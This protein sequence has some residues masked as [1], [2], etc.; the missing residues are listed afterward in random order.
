MEAP[1]MIIVLQK[2]NPFYVSSASANRTRS[3]IEG[4]EKL[5]VEILLY[6]TNGYQTSK[7][8]AEMGVSGFIGKIEYKYLCTNYSEGIWKKRLDAYVLNVFRSFQTI[9]S[10]NKVFKELKQSIVWVTN[11]LTHLKAIK[12]AKK[13]NL[14][15][16]IEISE[17]GDVYKYHSAN[18]LQMFFAKRTFNY[19]EKKAFYSLDGMALMTKNLVNH[20]KIYPK[21]APKLLHLPMTVD[22][23]RFDITKNYPLMEG[24]TKPYVAF[25]GDMNNFKDGVDILINA[26]ARI[27][28]DFP[29]V[30]LY[31][32][33][34]YFYDLPGHIEQIKKSRLENRIIYKGAVNRDQI[35]GIIMN[36]TLLVLARPDSKQA[37]GGFPTKLGEYLATGNPVC[38]TKVGE[39]PDYLQDD[40]SAFMAIP[41]SVESFADAMQRALS[42]SENARNV[43]LNGRKIAEQFF[44]KDIQSKT[45]YDF[46]MSVKNNK[47]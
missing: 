3:L 5:D 23:D 17:Y 37:Q 25:I 41:G 39:I 29:Q 4:L 9:N 16:F 10:L 19:F 45:L 36:A 12:L 1:I 34:F 21:P 30:N 7:E 32:F 6:I 44:N 31:L 40:F 28:P 26:F 43:G 18:F 2:H 8:K 42:N 22:L 13:Y 33:G 20:Y 15:T 14:I 27:A 24:L 35:P 46:L 11:D 38:V 47:N